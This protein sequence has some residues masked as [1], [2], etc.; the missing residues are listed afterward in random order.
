MPQVD[1][2]LKE[3]QL[4]IERLTQEIEALRLVCPLLQ[5]DVDF[6]SNNAEPHDDSSVI[7]LGSGIT[8][9]KNPDILGPADERAAC[10]ARISSRLGDN[11]QRNVPTGGR[12]VLL[13][14]GQAALGASRALWKRV[15]YNRSVEKEPPQG[16]IRN[17][18][19]RF[20]RHAA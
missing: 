7:R 20:G 9:E 16:A 12:N 18:F 15:L 19:E 5:D 1:E 14:V 13:Q 11:S 10:V 2:V 6:R 4:A 3:K 17:L 8:F